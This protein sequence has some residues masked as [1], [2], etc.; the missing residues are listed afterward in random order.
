MPVSAPA[1]IASL[2]GQDG[3]LATASTPTGPMRRKN[4]KIHAMNRNTAVYN[5]EIKVFLNHVYE[6]QKGVRRMILYTTAKKNCPFML[7]RL[8][9][10]NID[11]IIQPAGPNNINLFFGR[12]ECIQAIRCIVTRPLN[13]LSPEEDF[14][15]GA[16]L[17][18]DLC[19]QCERFCKR[20]AAAN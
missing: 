7:Q 12:K 16:M 20:K 14:I 6:F 15:L 2:S 17:G 9:S 11:Y 8:E 19:A 10:R 4:K 3:L 13:K 1:G 18:Y 5:S